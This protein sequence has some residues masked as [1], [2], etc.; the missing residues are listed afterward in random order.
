MKLVWLIGSLVVLA[1]CA[2]F[3]VLR[4]AHAAREGRSILLA[5]GDV[6]QV[7]GGL[8]RDVDD[9]SACAGRAVPKRSPGE[10]RLRRDAARGLQDLPLKPGRGHGP[11][12]QAAC[13]PRPVSLRRGSADF[14]AAARYRRFRRFAP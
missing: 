5:P 11:S 9:G 10:D 12:C 8:L 3:A 13:L 2:Y 14:L 6:V 7:S 1:L 4:P